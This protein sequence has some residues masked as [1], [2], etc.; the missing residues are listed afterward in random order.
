MSYGPSTSSSSSSS[1]SSESVG[2]GT[3]G[4]DGSHFNR[5][6]TSTSTSAGSGGGSSRYGDV[7]TIQR[8]AVSGSLTMTVK[9]CV[10]SRSGS[11]GGGEHLKVTTICK[12][13][14]PAFSGGPLQEQVVE[15]TSV[16][17]RVGS[18]VEME[19]GVFDVLLPP[20]GVGEASSRKKR[21]SGSGGGGGGGGGGGSGA[22]T[23]SVASSTSVSLRM[24]SSELGGGSSGGGDK[25]SKTPSSI[26]TWLPT[27]SNTEVASTTCSCNGPPLNAGRFTLH[28][29]VTLRCSPPPPLPLRDTTQYFTVIVREPDTAALWIVITSPY[30]LLP[31]PLPALVLVLVLARLK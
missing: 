3:G 1:S 10:V 12:V 7:M 6:S 22:R 5:A 4:G 13:K 30:L 14:R 16:F 26:S 2:E 9:Y 24:L 27:L 8:A 17:E 18:H 28:M 21:G 23:D 20:A 31:P 19:E 25:T 15:A 29:V 11:G